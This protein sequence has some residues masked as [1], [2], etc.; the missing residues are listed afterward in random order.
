VLKFD[1][2]EN[3][4]EFESYFNV[5]LRVGELTASDIRTNM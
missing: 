1:E 2:V 5:A 4:D 3:N